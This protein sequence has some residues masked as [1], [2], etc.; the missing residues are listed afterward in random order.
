MV[1]KKK[2]KELHKIQFLG[3]DF[4]KVQSVTN[5]AGDN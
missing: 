3:S 5:L 2:K 1:A 4:E